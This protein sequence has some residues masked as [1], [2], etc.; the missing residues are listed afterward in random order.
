MFSEELAILDRNTAIY[1]VDELQSKLDEVLTS[2]A[3]KNLQIADKYVLLAK[4]DVQLT[5]KYVLLADAYIQLSEAQLEIASIYR[6]LTDA[7]KQLWDTRR[8]LNVSQKHLND[9]VMQLADAQA[10]IAELKKRLHEMQRI[11]QHASGQKPTIS[12]T[13]IEEI[14]KIVNKTKAREEVTA[15]YMRQVDREYSLMREAKESGRNE[16]HKEDALKII[17]ID[18]KHQVPDDE[19]RKDISEEFGFSDS[20]IEELFNTIDS[21]AKLGNL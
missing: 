4:K 21:N 12:N 14:D 10:Q 9:K 2:L 3:G 19:I 15:A 17:R 20:V 1:M 13:D 7:R 5:D 8:K 18:R 6:E 11:I 16:A